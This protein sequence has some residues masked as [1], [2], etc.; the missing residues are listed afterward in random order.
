MKLS[1][2]FLPLVLAGCVVGPDYHPAPMTVPATWVGKQQTAAPATDTAGWWHHFN[3]P[4]LERL[5][6]DAL[7]S[8]ADVAEA[9]AKIREARASLA[10]AR[11]G[12]FPSL[13]LSADASR[14]RQALS[15]GELGGSGGQSGSSTFT[16]NTFESGFDMTFELDLFGGQRRSVESAGATVDAAQADLGST[17]LSLLG[18]VAR[19]YVDARA[20]QTRIS[21]AQ[22]TLA[23]R[24]DT[25]HLTEAKAKGGIG[26]WLDAVQAEAEVESAAAQIPPLEYGFRQAVD[27]LAVL[28][29]T[30]PQD[31]LEKLQVPRPIP[32]LAGSIQPDPP[33]VALARRPDIRAAERRLAAATADIGVAEADRYPGVTLAGAIGLNS[34]QLRSFA[35][36]SSNVWSFGPEV[37]LPIFDAG[38][39]AAKV[40][41]KTAIR[42]EK[43]AAWEATVRSAIEE[44]ENALTALDRERAHNE[45]L[46]RTVKAYA[47][48]L[49][50]SQA[51]YEAGL[52][53]FLDVLDA[54]RSLATE[55]DNLAQSD[56]DLAIDGIALYKALGGGWQEAAR[57]SAQ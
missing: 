27:R 39:R 10:Q 53:T 44:A 43:L 21:I 14:S 51:Q 15:G 5:V 32:H 54:D 37:S 29:G 50:V 22:E 13:D 2:L 9:A 52:A 41:Q 4:V 11:S 24:T 7:R 1:I 46:R 47:D 25:W 48:A 38:K 6:D 55:R 33:L 23:S 34:S 30:Q 56:A 31:V 19:Y 26:S 20:Y 17:I 36:T 40:D 18:D 3:D 45:A 57:A 42:D 35:E 8:N 16:G 12:L 28:T 49:R